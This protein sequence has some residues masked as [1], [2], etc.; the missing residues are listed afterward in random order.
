M[1]SAELNVVVI[2]LLCLLGFVVVAIETRLHRRTV[3]KNRGA[4]E[5]SEAD[6]THA[7]GR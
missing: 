3:L 5:H 4:A 1:N 6:R 7:A 2:G